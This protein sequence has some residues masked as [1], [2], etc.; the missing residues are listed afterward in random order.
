MSWK[1]GPNGHETFID[2]EG[3]LFVVVPNLRLKRIGSGVVEIWGESFPPHGA[4]AEF[5]MLGGC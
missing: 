2:V 4:F 3:G 1:E 5:W